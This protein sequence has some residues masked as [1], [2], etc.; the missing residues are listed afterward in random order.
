MLVDLAIILVG[1][2]QMAV[3]FLSLFHTRLCQVK[4]PHCS[5]VFNKRI[6]VDSEI[7]IDQLHVCASPGTMYCMSHPSTA[8]DWKNHDEETERPKTT[9]T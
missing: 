3:P 9:N 6:H 7:Q 1:H 4:I 8:Y 5:V 2:H